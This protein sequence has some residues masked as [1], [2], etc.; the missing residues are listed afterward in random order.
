MSIDSHESNATERLVVGDINRPLPPQAPRAREPG[1]ASARLERRALRALVFVAAAP[2][3]VLPGPWLLVSALAAFALGVRRHAYTEDASRTGWSVAATETAAAVLKRAVRAIVPGLVG[4]LARLVLLIVLALGVPAAL[5]A[6]RELAVHGSAGVLIAAR[7]AAIQSAPSTGAFLLCWALLRGGYASQRES[8]IGR[9]SDGGLLV[10]TAMAAILTVVC[11]AIPSARW[12][13][14]E[15]V[16]G[17]SSML[18]DATHRAAQDA[19]KELVD[20]E[21]KTVIRCLN[22][23]RRD[24]GWEAQEAVRQSDGSLAV[25]IGRA[26]PAPAESTRG[27]VSALVLALHNQLPG[28]VHQLS[29][30][31]RADYDALTIDRSGLQVGDPVRSTDSLAAAADVGTSILPVDDAVRHQALR[32]GAAAP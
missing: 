17:L 15:S 26:D 23:H 4:T 27:D 7:L 32:C 12:W 8:P 18:P 25:A 10:A 24:V 5:A 20:Y 30:R 2:A 9:M 21:V 29:V 28:A 16:V 3:L 1:S 31:R 13:P 14:A 11:V 6:L 19:E 22:T